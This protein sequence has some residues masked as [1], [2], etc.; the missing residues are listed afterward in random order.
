MKV[1]DYLFNYLLD[2]YAKPGEFLRLVMEDNAAALN[3]LED[4][5]NSMGSLDYKWTE[6]DRIWKNIEMR[7]DE[8]RDDQT[9]SDLESGKEYNYEIATT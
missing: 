7:V 9:F 2:D 3:W 6:D 5:W 8:L 4:Q 1:E